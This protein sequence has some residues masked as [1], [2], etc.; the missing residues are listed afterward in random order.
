MPPDASEVVPTPDVSLDP[1]F[2]F[3]VAALDSIA[4]GV[5]AVD[6]NL[7]LVHC[8][9]YAKEILQQGS[10]LGTAGGLI[11]CPQS[12]DTAHLRLA[13]TQCLGSE[14]SA[15]TVFRLYDHRLAEFIEIAILRC[16]RPT[17]SQQFAAIY[18]RS[19]DSQHA[20]SDTL[21]ADLYGLTRAE[22]QI[23][24][25]LTQEG[26]VTLAAKVRGVSASTARTHLRSLLRK[27]GARRQVDL[28]QRLSTGLGGM[29]RFGPAPSL[30]RTPPGVSP[31][32]ASSLKRGKP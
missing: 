21:L 13:I 12:A 30:P 15:P 16:G 11:T 20:V 5:I 14:T 2:S 23:A 17:D 4:V 7:R 26:S 22:R 6:R 3:L 8:N 18:V 32:N 31:A 9:T 1:M 27:T 10:C 24:S 25:L 19:P 29:M 28:V